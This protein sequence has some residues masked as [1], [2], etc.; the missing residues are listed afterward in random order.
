MF[1]TVSCCLWAQASESEKHIHTEG[2]VWEE[3]IPCCCLGVWSLFRIITDWIFSPL[4]LSHQW[5][6]IR[7][8][9]VYMSRDFPLWTAWWGCLRPDTGHTQGRVR[10][11]SQRA[12]AVLLQLGEGGW[13]ESDGSSASGWEGICG[14]VVP[15]IPCAPSASRNVVQM[16][17]V[18][19]KQT[20]RSCSRL[21]T[22]R[23]ACSPSAWCSVPRNE[24]QLPER[25][26]L[27]YQQ[28]LSAF[29]T[30]STSF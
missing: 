21:L 12:L 8:V 28:S 1:S 6:Q 25:V 29:W 2:P 13:E 3:F 23:Q 10:F 16:L 22:S 15:K 20:T 7:F 4:P 18:R 26:L 14:T 19:R 5:P 24:H 27:P 30:K 11:Q 9:S 17:R